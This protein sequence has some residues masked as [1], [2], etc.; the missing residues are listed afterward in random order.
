MHHVEPSQIDY[1][2]GKRV[3]ARNRLSLAGCEPDPKKTFAYPKGIVPSDPSAKA[4]SPADKMR[5]L[6]FRSEDIHEEAVLQPRRLYASWDSADISDSNFPKMRRT[7]TVA[8]TPS[9]SRP[10][11]TLVLLEFRGNSKAPSNAPSG[12]RFGD[13][14]KKNAEFIPI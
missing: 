14:R 1:R 8:P 6:N 4:A 11:D 3:E 13:A 7:L 2:T 12:I 5:R 10:I 9:I